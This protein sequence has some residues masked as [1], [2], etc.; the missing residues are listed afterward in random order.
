LSLFFVSLLCLATLTSCAWIRR[1]ATPYKGVELSKEEILQIAGNDKESMKIILKA[2]VR[3]LGINLLDDVKGSL[4]L[5]KPHKAHLRLYHLGM[6]IFDIAMKDRRIM[7]ASAPTTDIYNELGV[8]V[9]HVFMWWEDLEQAQMEVGKDAY[10]FLTEN[11]KVKIDKNTL[12]P[13]RQKFYLRGQ[14]I[15]I[16]YKNPTRFDQV[17]FP[18]TLTIKLDQERLDIEIEKLL[19]NPELNDEQFVIPL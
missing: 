19:L 9:Y 14:L 8:H 2:V 11:R 13:I 12:L 3:R 16:T 17:E 6:L 10:I 1:P 15:E 18:S 7:L 5:K 4:L